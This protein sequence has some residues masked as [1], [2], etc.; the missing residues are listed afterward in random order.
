MQHGP[1]FILRL[2]RRIEIALHFGGWAVQLTRA[3]G[4]RQ[5][6]K[7]TRFQVEGVSP[8][9]GGASLLIGYA[10]DFHAGPTTNPE[11][12]KSACAALRAI[13]PDVLLLGGDFVNFAPEDVNPLLP[14][15]AS[16]SAP[17]GRFAV[18]G[19]HDWLAGSSYIAEQLQH[20]GIQVLTNRNVR[21]APPF[22]HVWIC[23]LDDHWCGQ[24]DASGAF[25]DAD[26]FRI[27]LMHAPSGLLDIGDHQFELAFCGHTHGGQVALPGGRPLILP[28][29]ALSRRYA[30]GRY[31]LASGGTLVVSVGVGCAVLPVRMNADPEIIACTVAWPSSSGSFPG[32]ASSRGEEPLLRAGD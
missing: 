20:I 16:I 32:E 19:N 1:S 6:V 18:L 28:N 14:E 7:T 21:L 31:Q 9:V 4:F 2:V 29:G 11:I 15:L 27:V 5:T 22:E 13:K 25:E 26:G 8:Q 24:P 10:S 12:L 17:L 23:G 30:R 3:L